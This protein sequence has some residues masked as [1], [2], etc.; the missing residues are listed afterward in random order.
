MRLV[1]NGSIIHEGTIGSL[2][3]FADD[4]AKCWPATNAVCTW[5]GTTTSTKATSSRRTRSRKLPVP[6][7]SSKGFV[8]ILSAELYFPES[9]SLKGKR[10]YLRRIRDQVTRRSRGVVR[11]GG[12]PGSLAAVASGHRRGRVRP[13]GAGGDA[14]AAES[15]SGLPGVGTDLRATPRWWT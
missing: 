11:G 13:A 1:R 2:K 15:V 3:R 4:A 10:M 12:L 8:G 7:R 6:S 9:G 5:T 14:G